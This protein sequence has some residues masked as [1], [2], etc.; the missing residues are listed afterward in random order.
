TLSH[1]SRVEFEG[2]RLTLLAGYAD[3]DFGAFDFYSPGRGIPSHERVRSAFAALTGSTSIGGME[4]SAAVTMRDF[5]DRF[6]FDL[7]IPDQYINE[8]HTQVLG[9]DVRAIVP[10]SDA[11]SLTFGIEHSRDRIESSNLGSHER[12]WVAFSAV[13]QWEAATWLHLDGGIRWDVHSH[14]IPQF[15]PSIGVRMIPF[16]R[17]MLRASAG[18]S[19]R[20][21]TYTDLYYSDPVNKGNAALQ[22]ESAWSVESGVEWRP[23]NTVSLSATVFYRDQRDLID[24][25]Q[26]TED[27]AF[28]AMNFT[29]ASVTGSEWMLQWRADGKGVLSRAGISWTAISPRLDTRDAWRVRYS[30]TTPEHL[31]RLRLGGTLPLAMQWTL[32]TIAAEQRL[33]RNYVSIDARL[34]RS[35]GAWDA[36][37]AA[38]NLTNSAI[39]EF[40][41]LPLPGRWLRFG[42]GLQLH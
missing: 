20:L 17:L 14:H 23:L 42:M 19:F 3:K 26:F 27:Q 28:F 6:Q 4:V 29:R 36:W 1:L 31:L 12:S 22:P 21:P 30:F 40:P 39:E 11:A 24:Y 35:F 37:V 18:R 10:V 7:R 13:S 41:G 15:N 34:R 2:G 38:D 16:D 9:G 5:R 33:A 32:I 8:H 25:V